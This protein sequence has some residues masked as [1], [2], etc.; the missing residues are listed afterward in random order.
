MSDIY[1]LATTKESFMS[2]EEYKFIG[3]AF[4]KDIENITSS[5][6]ASLDMMCF[7]KNNSVAYVNKNWLTFTGTSLVDEL[8][9]GRFSRIHK[10]DIS[11]VRKAID[12]FLITQ[13]PYRFKYRL[14]NAENAY[15]WIVED[16]RSFFSQDGSSLGF[17]SKCVNIDKE[18]KMEIKLHFTETKYRRLFETAHDGIIIL[19]SSTGEITDINPFLLEL[20]GYSKKELLGKKIWEVGAF[21][22]VNENREAFKTLQEIGSVR[23]ENLPLETKNGALIAVEFV[24]NAYIAGSTRVIQCNIR[25]IRERKIAESAEKAIANLKQEYLKNAFITDVTHELRTPLAIIKGN[26]DLALRDK[27]NSK[28]INETFQSIN[29]EVKHLSEMILDLSILTTD[30]QDIQ[31]EILTHTVDLSKLIKHV[32]NRLDVISTLKHIVI[33]VDM[34]LGISM[35]GEK[36]YLEKLFSNI[37]SNAIYYGKENGSIHIESR[38]TDKNII[39]NVKD[40]GIGIAEDDLHNIFGRFYRTSIAREVNH[41]GTGLGLAISRWIVEAHKGE[42]TATSKLDKGTIFTIQFPLVP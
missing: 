22:N 26:I 35:L 34:T 17:V 29:E 30:N 24:S 37:I 4:K 38:K 6:E 18:K 11:R 41:E 15:K 1:S 14:L 16:G 5:L 19:N 27:K 23:Y 39:I 31:K 3:E 12:S 9:N 33:T 40:N 2:E 32:V 25:D 20:L 10:E 8:G 21:K 36:K 42:I 7:T 28:E 13:K